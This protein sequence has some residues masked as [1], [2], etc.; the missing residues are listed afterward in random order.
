MTI[1]YRLEL[2]NGDGVYRHTEYKRSLWAKVTNSFLDESIHRMPSKDPLLKFDDFFDR[3]WIFGFIS[4]EQY[5][6]WVFNP[7]WR[8]EFAKAGA[9]LSSYEVSREY[10]RQ[11][12]EQVIFI[13]DQAKKIAECRPDQF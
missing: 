9:I 12:M 13:R 7:Y 10:V 5:Q 6:H 11:G 8:R 1:V 4:I 3:H 2:P